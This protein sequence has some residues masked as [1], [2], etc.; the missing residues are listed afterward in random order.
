VIH[1][2]PGKVSLKTRLIDYTVV[3]L[4]TLITILA[5][6]YIYHEMNKVKADVIYARRKARYALS[7][8]LSAPD[9]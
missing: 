4:T 7:S 3:G 9:R 8:D 5:M 2:Y 1:D 6:W